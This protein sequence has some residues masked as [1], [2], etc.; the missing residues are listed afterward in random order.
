MSCGRNSFPSDTEGNGQFPG[1]ARTKEG[2]KKGKMGQHATRE[3]FETHKRTREGGVAF[4][5]QRLF[6]VS[7]TGPV[8]VVSLWT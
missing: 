2:R 7:L 8:V 3:I 5:T 6:L 1:R 4:V